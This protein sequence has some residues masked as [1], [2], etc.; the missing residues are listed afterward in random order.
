MRI[1]PLSSSSPTME[2]QDPQAPASN[3]PKHTDMIQSQGSMDDEECC[4]F[5]CI[6]GFINSILTLL[7]CCFFR[8]GADDDEGE[9]AVEAFSPKR[10]EPA[11][12]D[13]QLLLQRL[14]TKRRLVVLTKEGPLQDVIMNDRQQIY[15]EADAFYAT[16]NIPAPL[17]IPDFPADITVENLL[18]EL[19]T[20]YKGL[21][22][23]ESHDYSAPKYFFVKYLPLM[24]ELGVDTID[25]EGWPIE[26]WQAHFN[27][28]FVKG[29]ITPALKAA[30][31]D[32]RKRFGDKYSEADVIIAAK[33]AGVKRIVC[34]DTLASQSISVSKFAPTKAIGRIAGGNYQSKCIIER[35]PT[36]GKRVGWFG[37]AHSAQVSGVPGLG[38][39]FQV[40]TIYCQDL[41]KW[42]KQKPQKKEEFLL[43]QKVTRVD[44]DKRRFY[45]DFVASIKTPKR[46]WHERWFS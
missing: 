43:A 37:S 45:Y 17:E 2:H 39:M 13:R 41:E 24:V 8:D 10:G 25:I 3:L 9:E 27:A 35:T 32:Q 15:Q 12:D 5:G 38:Q 14:S 18:R 4:L 19:L 11:L 23:A 30:F 1:P 40:P 26:T 31:E 16:A 36:G 28:Y 44:P 33:K 42:G 29:E 46:P 21:F 6:R 34:V 20:R 7:C 22:V